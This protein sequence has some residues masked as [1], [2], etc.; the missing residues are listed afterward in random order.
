M[1][2]FCK[3]IFRHVVFFFSHSSHATRCCKEESLF[4]LP[5]HRPLLNACLSELSVLLPPS[6]GATDVPLQTQPEQSH[7]DPVGQQLQ[8]YIEHFSR[9]RR[10]DRDGRQAGGNH[11]IGGRNQFSALSAK[12]F[13]RHVT[14]A[15]QRSGA[16]AA[17]W[18]RASR[19][20]MPRFGVP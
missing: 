3:F 15:V 17:P 5:A 11:D 20:A 14:A 2:V 10:E 4:C 19:A 13:V 1:C 8:E 9:L 7:P 12:E 16:A 6:L 18:Q